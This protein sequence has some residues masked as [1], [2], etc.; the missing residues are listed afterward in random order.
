MLIDKNHILLLSERY[1]KS[2]GLIETTI[3]SRIFNDGKKIAAL[4]SGSDL[5]TSRYNA[6]LLWFDENWPGLDP[7]PSKVSRPSQDRGTA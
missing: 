5:T 4:R 6:A 1:Q 7:W 2:T 3:S